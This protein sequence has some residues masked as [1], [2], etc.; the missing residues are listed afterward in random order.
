VGD[1]VNLAARIQD[2]TKV[3]AKPI[4]IDQ[5]TRQGLS[6]DFKIEGLGPVMFKGKQQAVHIFAVSI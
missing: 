4:L 5:S 2:H 1:T 3:V 6:K